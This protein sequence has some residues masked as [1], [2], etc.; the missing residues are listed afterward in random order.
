MIDLYKYEKELISKGYKFISG[1][2]E[3]GRGSLAGPLVVASVILPINYSLEG[4]NDS[5]QVSPKKR[6][7]LYK[8][9]ILDALAY[10]IVFIDEKTID[11]INIYEATKKGM[12]ESIDNLSIKP[13][14]CLIDAMPL[15]ISYLHN[16]IIH[17]DALSLSIAAASI[18]AKVSRDHYMDEMDKLYPLYD[19]KNNKGYGT[20]K[21]L[22]ALNEYG[23]TKIHRMSYEPV[24][25]SKYKAISLDI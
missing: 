10:K 25:K 13:E 5:K 22:E 12:I 21:H 2:D 15:N 7:I 1:T 6:E 9:I 19:F 17:G 4:L 18:L 24:Y 23:P 3:A 8:R 14:Y 20:K 11:E 16:S